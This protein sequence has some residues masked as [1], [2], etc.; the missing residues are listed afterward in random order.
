MEEVKEEVKKDNQIIDIINKSV[1]NPAIPKLYANGFITATGHGD[2]V[3]VLQQ[4][5]IPIATLNL[6]YTVAKTLTLKL[7]GAVKD[8]ENKT[9]NII[10]VTDDVDLAL[11]NDKKRGNNE[12]E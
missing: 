12:G 1:S 10:M 3:I 5:N 4:N 9:G 2:F 7:G 8:L 11:I 6:S